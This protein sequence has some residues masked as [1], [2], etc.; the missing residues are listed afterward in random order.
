VTTTAVLSIAV[1]DGG[2]EP[3]L[4]LTTPRLAAWCNR[5]GY[6]LHLER[7]R[8]PE[9][10]G[11]AWAKIPEMLALLK[12][13]DHVVL[14]D[15]DTVVMRTDEPFPF[16]K[17]RGE[18]RVMAVCEQEV[19]WAGEGFVPNTGV[20]GVTR[21]A[22]PLLQEIWDFPLYHNEPWMEQSAYMAVVGYTMTKPHPPLPMENW[23]AHRL[24]SLSKDWNV[25]AS[26][27]ALLPTAI[28]RHASGLGIDFD[29]R[30]QL[31]KGWLGE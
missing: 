16:D 1:R 26:D 17:M 20:W 4:E 31:M 27:T 18:D 12:V 24:F 14:M 8:A 7:P 30:V 6:D 10:R 25:S 2:Y 5:H 19:P 3:L 11:P 23:V 21:G 22:I 28:V 9:G 15:C 29:Q 13:Y